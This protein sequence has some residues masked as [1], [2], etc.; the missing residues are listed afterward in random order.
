MFTQHSHAKLR[1]DRLDISGAYAVLFG[2]QLGVFGSGVQVAAQVLGSHQGSSKSP[3][4]RAN[5]EEEEAGVRV[6]DHH[7]HRILAMSVK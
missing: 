2:N 7:V 4:I 6:S 5:G 1:V 3:G